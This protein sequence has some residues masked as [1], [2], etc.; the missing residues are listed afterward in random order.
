MAQINFTIFFIYILP[1]IV[2]FLVGLCLWKLRKTY[3]LSVLMILLDIVF[4]CILS[5]INTHGSEGPGILVT[6]YTLTALGFT[7]VEIIK[8]IIRRYVK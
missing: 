5:N 1:V 6:M 8:L 3:I 2:G 7:F 4:W